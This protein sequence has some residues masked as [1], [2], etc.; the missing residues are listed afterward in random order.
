LY[1]GKWDAF[2]RVEDLVR[3]TELITGDA[4][5]AHWSKD[6][7]PG[8]QAELWDEIPI[9]HPEIMYENVLYTVGQHR[10]KIF[11][12]R[13]YVVLGWA[14][15]G[16]NLFR[17]FEPQEWT[18]CR[19]VIC[20]IPQSLGRWT[21]TLIWPSDWNSHLTIVLFPPALD[22]IVLP[23]V[24]FSPLTPD[25]LYPSRERDPPLKGE[26]V[27]GW[28]RGHAGDCPYHLRQPGK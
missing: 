9:N 5:L 10:F 6:H 23:R 17:K 12:I 20:A 16:N 19:R 28:L 14:A 24:I 18:W 27:D 7:E 13:T 8:F 22:K 15:D 25:N 3:E 26:W 11:V 2:L 1:T 21:A 4:V